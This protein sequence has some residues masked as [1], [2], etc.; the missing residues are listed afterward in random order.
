MK[1]IKLDMH[2]TKY[3]GSHEETLKRAQFS[4]VNHSSKGKL[5]PREDEKMLA[6]S[7][8]IKKGFSQDP[9]YFKSF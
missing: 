8:C 9:G 4:Q 7:N 1:T 6:V 2:F 5:Y 3:R